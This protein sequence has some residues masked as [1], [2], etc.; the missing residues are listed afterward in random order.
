MPPQCLLL[1]LR[2]SSLRILWSPP[3]ARHL[4]CVSS[5]YPPA[6]LPTRGDFTEPNHFPFP[7]RPRKARASKGVL[8]KAN[9]PLPVGSTDTR[10]Q[11]TAGAVAFASV[12]AFDTCPRLDTVYQDKV[13]FG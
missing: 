9:M 6:A 4:Y 10:Y 3:A 7:E 12:G 2:R 13:N 5:G 8:F 11:P 1:W